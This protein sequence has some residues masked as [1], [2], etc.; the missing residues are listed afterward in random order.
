MTIFQKIGKFFN[1]I[2]RR[3]HEIIES[4]VEPAMKVIDL[5]RIVINNPA[6]DFL[7]ALTKTDLDDRI[8]EGVR[9]W[10]PEVAEAWGLVVDARN[11]T[12]G[13]ILIVLMNYLNGLPEVTKNRLYREFAAQLAELMADGKLSYADAIVLVQLYFNEKYKVSEARTA[14]YALMEEAA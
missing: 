3:S 13:E 8:V 6:V 14:V 9:R 4:A 7:T 5:L 11:K 12:I 1:K 2:F 10:L